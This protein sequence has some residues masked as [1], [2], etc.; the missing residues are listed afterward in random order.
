M[1]VIKNARLVLENDILENVNLYIDNGEIVKTGGV[2]MECDEVIDAGNNYVSAGFIDIHTHGAGD[3]DFLDETEQAYATAAR[4]HAQHG[5]TALLPTL[6]SVDTEG[7]KKALEIFRS[8]KGKNTD[9][10][11]LLGLHLEGPY[12]SPDQ[13]GAQEDRFIRPFNKKEYSEIL[14]LADGNILRWSA[15]P[16]LSGSAE[17][18]RTLSDNGVL[19]SMGHSDAEY[20]CAIEAFH[21][22]FTH[23]THLYSCT[24]SVHR[25]N[26]YRF[27][28]IV[29]AS[30]LC[31]DMTVEIIADG[32]HL[33]PPLLKLVYKFKGADKIA[34]ITDSMRAAGMPDGESVLGNMQ[35]GLKVIVEDGVAKLPNRSAFAG[36]VATCDTLVRNMVTLADVPLTD[37]VKMMSATP[38]RILNIPKKGLIKEGYDADLVIFDDDINIKRTIIGGRVVF[39]SETKPDKTV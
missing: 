3:C 22:G 31:D 35:N 19:P 30:Y 27:A 38:A 11:E 9:G 32:I 28:G 17:F 29:E 10:A 34:L 15:A 14:S 37:A 6:T 12:F 24:S 25:R 4:V 8:V 5:T 39:D 16:E 1:K 18:A 36:S 13:K 23:V 20:D 2:E 26:G 33:P 7:I 21:N